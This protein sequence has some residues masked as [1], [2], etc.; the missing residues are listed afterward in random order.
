MEWDKGD[1]MHIAYLT[2]EYPHEKISNGGGMG[3]S[4]KNLV[5]A[6][7]ELGHEI[8]VFVYGQPVDMVFV[9]HKITF[10]LIAQKKYQL[11][12]FYFYRKHIEKYI[13]MNKGSIELLEAPDWTG[14]TAFMKLRLPLIIR[15][16]GSDTYFCHIEKRAQKIKNN[17]FE[18]NAVSKAKA[19]IAP[20]NFA[21]EV[22]MKLFQL[23]MDKLKVIPYGLQLENFKNEEPDV[24]TPFTL[25]NIGTLIRKKGVFQLIEVFNRIVEKF[26]EAQLL[27]IGGDSND[28]L[29]GNSSTWAMMQEKMT[30]KAR[31]NIEYL[32]KLPY[33]QVKDQ[34]V[35][36]HVC[37]FPS[38]AETLGM[39]TIESM[40]LSKAVVNTDIGWA[41]D[42]I[43]HGVDGYMHHPDDIG[44]YVDT[45]SMLFTNKELV[46]GLGEKATQTIQNK[47]DIKKNA[48][49]NIEF[50]KLVLNS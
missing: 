5:E 23:P 13:N 33:N 12:G 24:Y 50:Y 36:A 9:D 28:V 31:S 15:F 48:L 40:A 27:F 49:E 25:L 7:A 34:I 6:L 30:D 32:G 1:D 45:I 18:K 46:K 39:V 10:H 2:P 35:K 11:G 29:T 44:S 14:I 17:F 26:P 22:S 47:F 16:H 43:N 42:L 19:F 4:I 37:V 3:T 20:T 38:L 8:T 41:Q 21:G